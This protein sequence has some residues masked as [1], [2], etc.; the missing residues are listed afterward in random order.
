MTFWNEHTNSQ[1]Y[2]SDAPYS[3]RYDSFPY[4]H[5]YHLVRSESGQTIQA[6][7][8]ATAN[9]GGHNEVVTGHM[10][11]DV[12]SGQGIHVEAGGEV[13]GKHGIG[14]NAGGNLAYNG[15]GMHASGHIGNTSYGIQAQGNTQLDSSQG[16]GLNAE[17]QAFG[18]YGLA[19]QATTQ[20][21]GGQGAGL[22]VNGQIGK[23]NGQLGFT[24]GGKNQKAKE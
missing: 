24:I 23:Y 8:K 19:A 21:G 17:A 5:Y 7:E 3:P 10:N 12:G 22:D 6:T 1:A 14:V 4:S 9:Q 11:A 18:K 2:P 20:L 16:L 13:G 15:T